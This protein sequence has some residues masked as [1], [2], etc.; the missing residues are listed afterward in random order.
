M[1]RVR[2]GSVLCGRRNAVQRVCGG[3]V[4]WFGIDGVQQLQ[5]GDV[6]QRG[7]VGVQRV[8]GGSV[9]E[10]DGVVVVHTVP[11]GSLQR[12]QRCRVVSS[13]PCRLVCGYLRQ[14]V[15]HAV[16]VGAVHQRQRVDV[17]CCVCTWTLWRRG[18]SDDRK[19]LRAVRGRLLLSVGIHVGCAVCMSG[20]S[21]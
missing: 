20:W 8:C 14:C 9:R 7:R 2:A 4:Q 6:Q 10:H 17:V 13:L 12:C 19:L 5:C 3:P 18:W 11:S 16:S 1:F 15:L 21:I